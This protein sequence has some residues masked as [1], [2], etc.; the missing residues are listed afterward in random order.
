M[1][2]QGAEGE[3]RS[4]LHRGGS[5]KVVRL[6]KEERATAVNA[7]KIMGLNVCGVDL[8]NPKM[9]R[10]LW[11]LTHLPGSKVLKQQ[12]KKRCCRINI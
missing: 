12:L 5:A 7:A 9:G 10:W 1:K 8:Y 4:N 2:R 11:R 3:F 6:S